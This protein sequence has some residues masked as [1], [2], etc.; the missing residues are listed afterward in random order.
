LTID[1]RT[2]VARTGARRAEW[3]NDYA[4]GDTVVSPIVT[5]AAEDVRSYSRF[6][7]DVRPVFHS[8]T[9]A[10]SAP[11]PQLFLF[12]LGVALLLHGSGTYIPRYFVAFFGF[13]I[14]EFHQDVRTGASIQS[15]AVVSAMAER[16][17]NGLITYEH[18]TT[19]AG[20][21]VLVTST[22]RI[23]VERRSVDD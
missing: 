16:G 5:I 12:S 23:L 4:V 7:N 2:A 3:F 14:I 21:P 6:T 19:L 18:R 1:P 10:D 8:T 9:T 17:S 15:I 11:V 13:D 22:H 20:G